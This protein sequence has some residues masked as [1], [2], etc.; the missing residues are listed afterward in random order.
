MTEDQLGK[1]MYMISLNEVKFREII[2]KASQY[3]AN[4]ELEACC[5]WLVRNYNYPEAGNPLRAARRPKPPSLKEEA[6]A[7]L[8]ELESP[9]RCDEP[10]YE[11]IY[12]T[13]R[14]ALEALDD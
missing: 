1:R 6:L 8:A 2:S 14:L 13:I 11:S 5:E 4:Q 9:G 10:G 12:N 3:G 7:S